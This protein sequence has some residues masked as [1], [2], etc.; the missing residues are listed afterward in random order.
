MILHKVKDIRVKLEWVNNVHIGF[1]C[2]MTPNGNIASHTYVK[3]INHVLK[4]N[5]QGNWFFI[6]DWIMSHVDYAIMNK[7]D[8]M[9][10][11]YLFT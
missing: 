9:T 4:F 5:P 7:A 1:A 3:R 2:Q 10:F 11:F 8:K 6:F